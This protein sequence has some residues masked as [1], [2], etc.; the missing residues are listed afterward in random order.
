MELVVPW[1][2]SE[3]ECLACHIIWIVVHE[4]GDNDIRCPQCNSDDTVWEDAKG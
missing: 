1:K 4:L 2:V 3:A